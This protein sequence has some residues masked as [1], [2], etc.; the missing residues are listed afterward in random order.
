MSVWNSRQSQQ[1]NILVEHIH[2]NIIPSKFSEKFQFFFVCNFAIN[3][4]CISS[5]LYIEIYALS[6]TSQEQTC[7]IENVSLVTTLNPKSLILMFLL[8]IFVL[9]CASMCVVNKLL[10]NLSV[11]YIFIH[12]IRTNREFVV[13]EHWS[14]S[15]FYK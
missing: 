6:Q 9:I 7:W 13:W 14:I 10:L 12:V 1:V 2:V 11:L 4:L 8:E 3:I 5:L 15:L